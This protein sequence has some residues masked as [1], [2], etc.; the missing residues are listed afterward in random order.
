LKKLVAKN[1]Y[2]FARDEILSYI[3][4]NDL[5]GLQLPAETEIAKMMG[6]S[7]NTIREAI[8]LLEHE[9]VLYSRHGVGTFVVK[10]QRALR[11]DI[12]QFTSATSIIKD[13]GYKPGTRQVIIQTIAAS[14]SIA[15]ILEIEKDEPV[16][17]LERVRTANGEP[18][19]FVRD[20]LKAK[21]MDASHPNT[22]FESLLGYLSDRYSIE[23]TTVNCNIKAK[24]SDD[25]I[26]EKLELTQRTPLLV[27]EQVHYSLEGEAIFYSD[28]YFVSDKFNFNLARKR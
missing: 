5:W 17:Y 7:R 27:L 3:K 23:I 19:V 1:M 4:E 9:G 14:E 28:S 22:S 15:A 25:Y 6:V 12:S 16:V 8:R 11:T 2:Q 18:V 13:H 20:Y 21:Y 24:I 26:E 10:I